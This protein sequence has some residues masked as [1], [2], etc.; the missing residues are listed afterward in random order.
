M[1]VLFVKGLDHILENI[2]MRLRLRELEACKAVCRGWNAFIKS[3]IRRRKANWLALKPRYERELLHNWQHRQ[4]AL[5]QTLRPPPLPPAGLGSECGH[6]CDLAADAAHVAMGVGG[7]R[8]IVWERPTGRQ[9]AVVTL[10]AESGNKEA[11]YVILT[12]KHLVSVTGA[13]CGGL[14]SLRREELEGDIGGT[15][16]EKLSLGS[17]SLSLLEHRPLAVGYKTPT[18]CRVVVGYESRIAVC[19]ANP[20]SGLSCAAD[21]MEDAGSS[22]RLLFTVEAREGS[23][24]TFMATD[25]RSGMLVYLLIHEHIVVH[26]LRTNAVVHTI[27]DL[28]TGFDCR[29]HSLPK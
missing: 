15:K 5:V 24:I 1:D 13:E 28:A 12:P 16:L 27:S 23:Q 7:G 19:E 20:G 11:P 8:V 22:V 4:P 17:N 6:R 29:V 21:E 26:S 2:F 10:S 18:K 25:D 3:N 14:F 9:T